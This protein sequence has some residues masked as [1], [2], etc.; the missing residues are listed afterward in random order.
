MR[1]KEEGR[2]FHRSRGRGGSQVSKTGRGSGGDG[3][4]AASSDHRA[5]EK[6]G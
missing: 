4:P 3:V 6:R 5:A 1:K 2:G